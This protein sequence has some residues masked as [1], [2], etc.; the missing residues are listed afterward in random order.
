MPL[1][2]FR[3]V[4]R[5][6]K[7]EKKTGERQRKRILQT[8]YY[9]IV[10]WYHIVNGRKKK[11]EERVS[12]HCQSFQSSKMAHPRDNPKPW[13]RICLGD[14]K[15]RALRYSRGVVV[16]SSVR[17]EGWQEEREC[18]PIRH[19]EPP[20]STVQYQNIQTGPPCVSRERRP[21]TEVK[22]GVP[23]IVDRTLMVELVTF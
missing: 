10:R 6:K 13:Q 8:S 21:A 5:E 20:Y 3:M 17:Q 16:L 19:K 15:P 1:A 23:P 4:T 22:H 11:G 14:S 2:A 7:E 18:K 12:L 9:C